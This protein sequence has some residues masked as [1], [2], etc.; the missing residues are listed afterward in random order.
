MSWLCN[1][2]ETLN[3]DNDNICLVCNSVPPSIS[4]ISLDC[5][6]SQITWTSSNV[7]QLT[8]RYS[9]G[10]FN[11]TGL[12]STSIDISVVETLVFIAK[13]DV[14]ERIFR[15]TLTRSFVQEVL[16]C[17]KDDKTWILA[18]RR[19]TREDIEQ[20]LSSY[21]D[22]RHIRDAC[23]RL[24]KIEE[25]EKAQLAADEA[26]WKTTFASKAESAYRYYITHFPSGIHIAEANKL[27]KQLIKERDDRNWEKALS[28]NTI[29]SYREYIAVSENKTREKEANA[30]INKKIDEND[31]ITAL[32]VDTIE[33]YIE[34]INKHH[35]PHSNIHWS[36]AQG[37]IK[38]LRDAEDEKKWEHTCNEDSLDAYKDY[39]SKYPEG[40]H[41]DECKF[42]IDEKAWQYAVSVNTI[43]SY[44]A[45]VK[46]YKYGKHGTDAKTKIESLT[47]ELDDQAWEVARNTN[48]IESYERYERNHPYGKHL[49]DCRKNLMFLKE[50]RQWQKARSSNTVLEYKSYLSSFPTGLHAEEARKKIE[51]LTNKGNSG[52]LTVIIVLIVAAII[53][54]IVYVYRNDGS[55]GPAFINDNPGMLQN[56]SS[57]TS[58][59]PSST[60]GISS[61]E[62]ATIK[63]SLD[64]RLPGMEQAKKE[65]LIPT[66]ISGAQKQINKLKDA[67]DPSWR[68]YQNRLDK[69]K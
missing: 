45:Y 37:A 5:R 20:Y 25:E 35:Y 48:S 60:D 32:R 31:W 30:R 16:K 9:Q 44:Q 39:L 19:G 69:L 1:N 58:P 54:Y 12:T 6:K 29:E 59:T 4:E 11:V 38:R 33:G 67:N 63:N 18:S 50:V 43:A 26:A 24:S 8:L 15:F 62:I 47:I 66:G 7:N 27:L 49:Y 52:C 57:G 2:C 14:A 68:S 55:H 56:P 3:D 17:K 51:K 40:N 10:D 22:G 53:G 36:E 21:P 28:Y 64:S 46:S 61:S 41:T 13:N 65:G 34:Y 23:N 42:H